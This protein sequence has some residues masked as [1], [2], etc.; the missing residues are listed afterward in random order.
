MLSPEGFQGLFEQTIRV[1]RWG[2]WMAPIINSFLRPS[3]DPSWYNQDGGVRT[4]AAT[5]GAITLPAGDFRSASLS[6]FTG[7]LA[8]DWLR[9]LIWIDH[10]GLRV[11]T[12][13]NMTFVGGDR[14]DEAMARFAGHSA[15]TRIIPEG[16]RRFATWTPLLIPFYI[17]R[18]AEWDAAWTG[19]ERIRAAVPPYSMP[20]ASLLAAYLAAAGGAC[21]AAVLIARK[22]NLRSPIA[23]PPMLGAPRAVTKGPAGFALSDGYMGLELLSDGRGY[24]YVS[25]LERGGFAIDVTRRP[26]DPLQLRGRFFYLRDEGAAAC[27]SIGYEPA[28]IAGPDY[29]VTQPRPD[30]LKIVNSFAGVRAEAEVSLAEDECLELWRICLSNFS[31]QPRRLVLTSFQELALHETGAYVRD[32]DF[33]AMHVETW[34]I[35][36]INAIFARNRL[37]HDPATG[38]MSKEIVFHAAAP[39]AGMRLAGYEDSRTRFIGTGDLRRPQ[40]LEESRPRRP[41]DVGSL[42]TFDPAASFAIAIDLPPNGVGEIIFV[43]GHASDEIAAARLAAKYFGAEAPAESDLRAAMEATRALE[44]LPA[45]PASA[46]PFAFSANGAELRLTHRTPRPWAHVLASTTGNGAVV[47]NEGEIHSFSGNAR[48]NALTPFRFESVAASLPGQLIY[49]VDLA[50]GEADAAGF[51][52]FRR[53]DAQY[54]VAYELGA[55][56]FRNIRPETELELTFFVLP[57]DSADVRLLTIRNR[58]KTPKEFRVAPYFEIALA[59]SPLESLGSIESIRDERTEALLFA[60]PANDFEKGWAFAATSLAGATAETIRTRFIGARGRDLTNPVMVETGDPDRSREDDG[61]RVAAFSGVVR[62][63]AESEVDVAVVL[64][65]TATRHQAA[66]I[67]SEL[68]DPAAARAALQATR[69]WWAE[70]LSAVRIETNDPAFDR[71]VNHWLPYQVLV[72]RLWGRTGPNQ[73]GGATGFRDQ[74]QDVLP[75]LFFDPSLARRQ[76]VLHAGQQFPEGDVLKWWHDAPDGR[77]GFGQRTRAS[78]PHL[79]LP[80]VVARYLS[81]TGD[82][83]VLKEEVAYLEGP[84][85]PQGS[86]DLFF[87]PRESKETGD[88]YDHCR[89]AIAHALARL[90]AHGLPLIGS[91]DW[92]DGIDRIGLE[93]RGESVWLGFFLHDVLRDFSEIAHA[94][95]GEA[96]ALAY[97]AAAERLAGSLES[98]WLGERY[99]LAFADNGQTLDHASAMTAA[100]PILSGAVGF[101][102]GRVAL[103]NG[104]ARLEKTDRILLLT[105][106]FDEKSTPYPGRIADYPPGVRENGGQYS[107]GVSWTVDAYVRLAD[108][109]RERGDLAL[110]AQLKAR[111]FAC[112]TKIS[113]LGKTEGA[114]LAVYGLAPHQQPADIYDGAGYAG[115]GGWSWYTGSA[116]RMLSAAY[117][118]LGLEVKNEEIIAPGDLFAPKGPLHVKAIHLKG[119]ALRAPGPLSRVFGRSPA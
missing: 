40:G 28:R 79:W 61:H 75:F 31:D 105:P 104:L 36:K 38:R 72:S 45:P 5:V 49:V 63:P 64:G 44:P 88:V 91:G 107:H 92:N 103:E 106:P 102:R 22:W 110:A 58:A 3:P 42:Y 34:F 33:N 65:Q 81:A 50:S 99:A 111:A 51:V 46:W 41:D 48:Q 11:A 86:L 2:L 55:A 112:W 26:T 116:A 6:I 68:R 14:A 101:E 70:R 100:W 93:G 84:A 109:A 24:S 66:M 29:S 69:T 25:A 30:R 60:N 67:A 89:R 108:I 97:R 19:A 113:P 90:G 37:L 59:E 9:V 74:L 117:A 39:G 8:Y 82:A 71:L 12:L 96:A 77:T 10:M 62:V 35:P 1:L 73:R 118:I 20:V 95:E 53:P 13:V 18:G 85:I 27:W 114:E 17:P 15:R 52:P 43:N 32:P 80:Y 98:A 119:R 76:I 7:L 83:S 54:E 56:V 23:G 47:S 4:V 21:L 94:R 78:D 87:A 57:S 16:I 115:R